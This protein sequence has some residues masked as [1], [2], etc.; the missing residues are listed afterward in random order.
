MAKGKASITDG[1]KKVI[2]A[3]AIKWKKERKNN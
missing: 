1:M 3:T 2:A